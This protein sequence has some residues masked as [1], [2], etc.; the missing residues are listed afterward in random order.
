MGQLV[1]INV[2]LPRDVAWR[3]QT[4]HTAIWKQPVQ[5]RIAVRR[6]NLEGDGQGDIAGHGGENRA[7]MVYQ[8]EAYHHW[9]THF[10]RSHFSLGQFGEN[11]TVDG[12]ADDEVCIGDRYRIG[13]A[14]FEVTQPRG[15][16]LSRGYQDGRAGN[17][18]FA[19]VTSPAWLLLSR[20]GG[21]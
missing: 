17:G 6:L 14:L 5:G 7:V 8:M 11:F 9:Q 4:I 20:A 10:G 15:H 1:S 18:C 2:G 3:G 12:L 16:M 21:R 19:R 13:S